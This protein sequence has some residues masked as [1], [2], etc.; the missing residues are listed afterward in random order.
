MDKKNVRKLFRAFQKESRTV[1]RIFGKTACTT[2]APLGGVDLK[3]GGRMQATGGEPKGT[4]VLL[5]W[6]EDRQL[7]KKSPELQG[8]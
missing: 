3:T 5:S 4:E 6:V 1:G 2:P 8:A 7:S